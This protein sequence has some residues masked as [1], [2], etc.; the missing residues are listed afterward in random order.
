[1]KSLINLQEKSLDIFI[2]FYSKH[3][4][5]HLVSPPSSFNSFKKRP[6]KK[7]SRSSLYP[8]EWMKRDF[9]FSRKIDKTLSDDDSFSSLLNRCRN[10]SLWIFAAHTLNYEPLPYFPLEFIKFTP[11]YHFIKLM[12]RC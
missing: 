8:S 1:M 6:V 2:A 4:T 7:D 3:R 12:Q 5:N 10:S 9:R 11:C